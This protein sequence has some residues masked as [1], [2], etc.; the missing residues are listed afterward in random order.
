MAYVII[1]AG[2]LENLKERD[3][4]EDLGVDAKII[5]ERILGKSVWKGVDWVH[6]TQDRDQRPSG[7]IKAG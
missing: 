2:R 7:S 6:L 3:K 5:L 1:N 4:L